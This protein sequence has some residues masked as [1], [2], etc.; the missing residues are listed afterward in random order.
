MTA[1]KS[2]GGDLP[3]IFVT[4]GLLFQPCKISELGGGT[5]GCLSAGVPQSNH[6]LPPRLAHAPWCAPGP[7]AWLPFT[8]VTA[9]VVQRP[10]HEGLLRR[11]QTPPTGSRSA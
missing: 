2:A 10:V 8:Q 3:F 6:C 5:P 1:E 9:G 11:A 4:Q 7:P